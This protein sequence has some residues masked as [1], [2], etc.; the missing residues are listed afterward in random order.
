M[1]QSASQAHAFYRDVAKNRV[2][3]TIKDSAGFPAPLTSSGSRSQPFWSSKS[4]IARVRK[5]A[6]AYADFEPVEF[7]W[8]EF[9]DRLLPELEKDGLLVG[10]NWSGKN[11]TGY[12]LEPARVREAIESLIDQD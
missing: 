9:R 8:Q 4:R 1:G 6:P 11:V 2:V 12:D 7:S 3:W 10:V 5:V